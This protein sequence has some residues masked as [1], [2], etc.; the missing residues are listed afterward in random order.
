MNN[1]HNE[2]IEQLQSVMDLHFQGNLSLMAKS[3]GVERSALWR[4]VEGKTKK[5]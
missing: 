1:E 4:A 2:Q 5:S 3:I